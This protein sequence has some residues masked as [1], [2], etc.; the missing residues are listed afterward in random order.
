VRFRLP[1]GLNDSRILNSINHSFV[2]VDERVVL[3]EM[4]KVC[5]R[6]RRNGSVQEFPPNVACG[7]AIADSS[8]AASRRPADPP[9]R[10]IYCAWISKTSSS[11]KNA[12]SMKLVP[13]PQLAS[14]WNDFPYRL[15]AHSWAAPNFFRRAEAVAG[16][17]ISCLPSVLTSSGVS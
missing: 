15:C 1:L 5:C 4:K 14:F 6:H 2:A 12:G 7:V 13:Q 3:A 10:W 17:M 16:A 11:D 9:Y 8:P